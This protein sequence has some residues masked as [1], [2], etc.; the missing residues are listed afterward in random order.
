MWDLFV[1]VSGTAFAAVSQPA[2]PGV[3][4]AEAITSKHHRELRTLSGL[5]NKKLI[6]TFTYLAQQTFFSSVITKYRK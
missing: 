3:P 6:S 1:L 4:D 5:I 2:V